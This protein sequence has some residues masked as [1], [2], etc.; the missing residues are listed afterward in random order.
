MGSKKRDKE[1]PDEATRYEDD[2]ISLNSL[3]IDLNTLGFDQIETEPTIPR[4]TR[5]RRS[6]EP[7]TF[8]L[9]DTKDSV[10]IFGKHMTSY[11]LDI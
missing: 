10:N 2:A 11:T 7:S 5:A 1:R 9:S 3:N 4:N 8:C 6:R